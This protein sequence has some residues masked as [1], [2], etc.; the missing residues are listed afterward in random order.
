MRVWLEKGGG[1]LKRVVPRIGFIWVNY[2]FWSRKFKGVQGVHYVNM[3]SKKGGR[4]NGGMEGIIDSEC[5]RKVN[6]KRENTKYEVIEH[7][8]KDT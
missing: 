3:F 4:A 2:C 5:V 6:S 8:K 1:F 7:V